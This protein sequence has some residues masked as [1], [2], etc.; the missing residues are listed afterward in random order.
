MTAVNLFSEDNLL[1]Q[2]ENGK[3]ELG[4]Y[5]VFFYVGQDGK[6]SETETAEIAEFYLY[7]SGGTLRDENFNIVF[8]SSKFDIY[9][10]FIPP[11]LKN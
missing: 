6:P 2:I 5:K 1:A 10:G 4:F 11:H 8:Y 9:R 3:Y 7:P